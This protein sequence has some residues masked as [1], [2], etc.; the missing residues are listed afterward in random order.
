MAF[1]ILLS[2]RRLLRDKKVAGFSFWMI[3]F[4]TAWGLC[5]MWFYGRVLGQWASWAAG[6]LVVA[7]NLLYLSLI[8]YYSLPECREDIE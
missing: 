1:V 8:G 2:V 7:A 6:L 5:N 4:P 3:V